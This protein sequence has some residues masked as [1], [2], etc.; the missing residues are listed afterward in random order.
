M[1]T[2]SGAGKD[3]S[4]RVVRS[5]VGL[6]ERAAVAMAGVKGLWALQG[7]AA[8]FGGGGGG[9]E[10]AFDRFLVTA[11]IGETRV[12]GLSDDDELEEVEEE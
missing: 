11:F 7:P 3:G 9:K 12:L 5:G 1:V 6:D 4:V 8:A 2:C 10:A